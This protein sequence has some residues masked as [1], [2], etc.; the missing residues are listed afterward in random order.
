[1]AAGVAVGPRLRFRR[2]APCDALRHR[3][4]RAAVRDKA[5]SLPVAMLFV[6][7]LF[8]RRNEPLF[9]I[10]AAPLAAQA[11]TARFPGVG[12]LGGRIAALERFTIAAMCVAFVA[13]GASFAWIVQHTPPAVPAV[14]IARLAAGG[15]QQRLFCENF[16]DCSLA[17]QYSNVKVFLDGR[18]DPYPL[19]VWRSYV[20]AI[21]VEPGWRDILARYDVNAVV[22]PLDSPL[23][24]AIGT[25]SDMA[26][27]L[28]R[29]HVRS[30]RARLVRG[31]HAPICAGAACTCL[32]A[33]AV[34]RAAVSLR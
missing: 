17:L 29:P 14:A 3:G 28:S 8:A 20:S 10:A 25:R 19:D 16:S 23:A 34:V 2:V 7:A 13:T 33:A 21:R 18:C 22:A 32:A 15:G 26:H 24:Q 31:S 30:L 5:E 12:Q 6:A 11:L 4:W 9:A 27:G 1:M